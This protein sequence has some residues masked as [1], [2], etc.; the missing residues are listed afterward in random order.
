ML[1]ILRKF[2]EYDFG[3]A[4]KL[5]NSKKDSLKDLRNVYPDMSSNNREIGSLIQLC[6]DTDKTPTAADKAM[7]RLSL[8]N[9]YG[10]ISREQKVTKS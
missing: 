10:A 7:M 2:L 9:S 3:P 8:H 4:L 1:H 5:L 6:Q